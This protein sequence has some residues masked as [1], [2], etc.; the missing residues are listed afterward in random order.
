MDELERNVKSIISNHNRTTLCYPTVPELK[1]LVTA[2]GEVKV[3]DEITVSK[4]F[5]EYVKAKKAHVSAATVVVYNATLKRL[6]E[7]F[8]WS[9]QP[10]A[11]SSFDI[12]FDSRFKEYCFEK[13]FTKNTIAT[14]TIKRL[15]AIAY[16]PGCRIFERRL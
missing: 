8:Q 7:Y 16:P 13:R 3:Q 4:A 5:Q 14:A 12:H 9:K 10:M 11:W 1:A 15:K 6:T 2:I